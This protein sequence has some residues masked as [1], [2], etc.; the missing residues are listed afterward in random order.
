[1]NKARSKYGNAHYHRW[2]RQ[3]WDRLPVVSAEG[4]IVEFVEEL[5]LRFALT[6]TPRSVFSEIIWRLG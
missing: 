2:N 6:I 1:M 5:S 4:D 3:C